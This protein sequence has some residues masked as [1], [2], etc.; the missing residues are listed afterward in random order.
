M[1]FKTLSDEELNQ[2]IETSKEYGEIRELISQTK[3]YLQ[4]LHILI[5]EFPN[6]VTPL[7]TKVGKL[8]TTFADIRGNFFDIQASSFKKKLKEDFREL[9]MMLPPN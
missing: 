1:V 5:Q 8:K 7:T 2:S 4:C 6:Q 3:G 9:P